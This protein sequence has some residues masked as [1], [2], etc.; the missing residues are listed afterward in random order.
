MR[1]FEAKEVQIKTI[2]LAFALSL[3]KDMDDEN[4]EV[5]I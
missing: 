1:L 2:L 3:H 4:K 5:S